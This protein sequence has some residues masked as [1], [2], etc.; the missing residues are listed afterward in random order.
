MALSDWTNGALGAAMMAA[1]AH[2]P[3]AAAQA[4]DAN[5]TNIAATTGVTE[6]TG[7]KVTF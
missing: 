2:T 4:Q 7:K 6:P 1:T 3:L 5:L